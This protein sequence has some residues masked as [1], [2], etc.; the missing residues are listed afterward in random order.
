M[1]RFTTTSQNRILQVELHRVDDSSPDLSHLGEYHGEPRQGSFDRKE[2]GDWKRNQYQYFTPAMSGEETGNPD[3]PKQDYERMEAYNRGDWHCVGVYCSA[4]AIVRGVAVTIRS[5]GLWGIES[6]SSPEHFA[7]V[8]GEELA[9]IRKQ[10]G[11]LGFGKRV[12][13]NAV[14]DVRRV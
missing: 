2:L 5:D 3:S 6:D 11:S 7:E 9:E 1:K 14:A 10:L 13:D 4:T 12:I 8:E